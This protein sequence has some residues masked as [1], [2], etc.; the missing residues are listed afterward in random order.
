M[1]VCLYGSMTRK[2][3]GKSGVMIFTMFSRF[4]KGCAFIVKRNIW[5]GE[6]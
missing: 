4:L 1:Y 2:M 6:Q 3:C 5:K